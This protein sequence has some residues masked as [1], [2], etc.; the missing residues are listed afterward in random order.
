MDYKGFTAGPISFS[1]EE[2]TFSG[3][4]TG[5]Q[6]VIHFEGSCWGEIAKAFRDSI[7]TY[8]A[9]KVQQNGFWSACESGPSEKR[10]QQ[11]EGKH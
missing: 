3:T 5:L 2:E 11:K 7:D 6:D 4:V 9:L 10:G 8:L 1:L